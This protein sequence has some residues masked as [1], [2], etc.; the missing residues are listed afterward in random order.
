MLEPIILAGLVAAGTTH[1][2]SLRISSSRSL[3]EVTVIQSKTHTISIDSKSVVPQNILTAKQLSFNDVVSNIPSLDTDIEGNIFLRNSEKLT[4]LI[5]GKPLGLMQENRGDVLLQIPASS[6]RKIEVTSNPSSSFVSDGSAG[7]IN[8]VT[9]DSQMFNTKDLYASFQSG[10]KGRVGGELFIAQ[11]L[12]K[13]LSLTVGASARKDYR[14]RK[15]KNTTINHENQSIEKQNNDAMGR[16]KTYTSLLGLDY[17]ASDNVKMQFNGD[18]LLSSYDRIGNIRNDKYNIG[19]STPVS[20]ARVKR[21]NDQ[22]YNT[23]NLNYDFKWNFKRFPLNTLSA[24]VNYRYSENIERNLF[25]RKPK[26]E[27]LVVDSS[28]LSTYF[29]EWNTSLQHVYFNTRLS[30]VYS[31]MAVKVISGFNGRFQNG[32]SINSK[33]YI[34]PSK[35]AFRTDF[36]MDRNITSL[37]SEAYFQLYTFMIEFGLRLENETRTYRYDR[38]LIE[39]VNNDYCSWDLF[40]RAALSYNFGRNRLQAS[41]N[42]RSNRPLISELTPYLNNTDPARLFVGNPYLKNETADLLALSYIWK[43]SLVSVQPTLYYTK[44]KNAITDLYIEADKVTKDNLSDINSYGIELSFAYSPVR[45]FDLLVS[46]NWGAYTL[47]GRS[48]GYDEKKKSD[49]FGFQTNLNFRPTYSTQIQLNG[50]YISDRLTIQGKI[51]SRYRMNA[52]ISQKIWNNRLGI[53]LSINDI[54]NSIGEKTTV[55]TEDF[56]KTIIRNR[57]PQVVM[58]GIDF[59]L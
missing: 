27:V 13:K 26:A 45:W 54:F 50:N 25:E 1:A 16:P 17:H 37:Y 8:I 19:N 51:A 15:F 29:Q 28:A 39:L 53:T 58:M 20:Q 46:G 38:E 3:D 14:K 22:R 57:D 52:S 6:I 24:N 9:F 35:P 12:N 11:P 32:V 7:I 56:E 36:G 23:F 55:R 47:D 18:M 4:I 5:N 31:P 21:D 41:Y 30:E 43:N 40:P 48:I 10:S 59:T 42:R 49:T 2:D 34:T 33:D 44:I